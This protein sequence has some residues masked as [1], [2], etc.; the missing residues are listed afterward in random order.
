MTVEQVQAYELVEKREIQELD[1]TGYLFRHKKT[2]AR[3]CV[4]ENQ[5]PNKVFYIGFR[6]PAP[7]DTGVPHI[8]EH[9]VLCGSRLFPAK[10][11][12]VELAKGSLNTFLNAMTYPDKTVYPVA[13][14]NDQDFQNLMHVYMDAVFYP[15]IY[16]RKEI[17][18]QEGWHY[19][20][21]E[22]EGPLTLNGVVYNEMKGAFSSPEGVL[23]REIL[24]S[25]YPDTTY[26]N[27]SGGDPDFIP[28]LKYSEFLDF[29]SRY[30]HPSN[31][32]IYLYGDCDMG[33]KLAWLDEQYLSKYDHLPI[34][35]AIQLQKPF[36]R[37]VETSRSYSIS[38]EETTQ[39][40]TYLS[41]NKS[42]STTLDAKL[43]LAMQ[44]I[45]YVLLSAPG[46]PLKQALLDA[47]IG[48][49]ILSSYDNGVQQPV[50]SII[51]KNA[52]A[53]QKEAFV[54]TIEETLSRIAQEGINERALEAGINFFE[55]RYREADF[56]NYPPGL[57]YGLQALDSWLY[58]DDQV[59]LHLEA[60]DNFGFMRQQVGKGYF[61]GLIRTWLLENPHGSVVI[62][63]PEQGL[64]AKMDQQLEEKL[65][66]Y[67][68]SLSQEERKALIEATQKLHAYQEEPSTQEDLEKIPMLSRE[69]IGKEARPFVNEEHKNG[70]T[71]LVFHQV[72]TH[73]IGYVS[74]IFRADKVPERLFPYMG[75]LKGILGFVDTEHYRY[76]EFFNE[77]NRK[78][79]GITSYVSGYGDMRDPRAYTA[80]FEVRVKT[81]YENLEFAFSM[82]EEMLCRSRFTDEKRLYEIVAQGKSRLQMVMNTAGHSMASL[83]ALSYFSR[84]AYLTDLTGG[85]AFY[86]LIEGL[87][88]DFAGRKEE[89]IQNLQEL[90]NL[91]IR[92]ENLVVSYTGQEESLNRTLDY[93]EKLAGRLFTGPVKT[94]GVDFVPVEKNEGLRTS[95]KIQYV[96]MAGN[97][98]EAGLPY[99]GTLK[100][101]RT[102]MSYDYLWNHVRVKGGAYGC[103]NSYTRNG[104][105]YL[106]SYRD[107]N[108]EKT[109]QVYENSVEFVKNFQIS[110]RDM[111]RFI[112]GTISDMDVPLTPHVQG[113][114][115]MGAYL[116]HMTF[117]DVQR[118]RDEVLA[119]D[120]GAIQELAPYLQAVVEQRNLCVIGNE[121]K[122]NSQREL[123][124]E[125]RNLFH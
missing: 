53:S 33:E 38:A 64:T 48:K 27:E 121:E 51:A 14:C 13:S 25:L 106:V 86:E 102:I 97:F 87:E 118:E 123:F 68:A 37:M 78:T 20:M 79:G 58:A 93:V 65:E 99:T 96:A 30:Y 77:V 81:L 22:P 12:F 54:K 3:V 50:F 35:S 104:D 91:L 57:M 120:C 16:E 85:V 21:E 105:A 1:S 119:A 116:N 17:F 56:G 83:R 94:G 80:T 45:E 70:D 111:T 10:D 41:Y 61:E 122:L 36:T 114:R 115:S 23:D 92:R 112:I 90:V 40:N 43:Y 100:V 15:N 8:M 98:R 46:A 29:H 39:D 75:I 59:F 42:V 125:L 6:T 95:S 82:L 9:S 73:G 113:I 52:N 109:L 101:L 55:F 88:A 66:N 89:F 26:A 19:E 11:P 31:S 2:R 84:S 124:G 28:E 18:L 32:Y 7:D 107:P 49:D 24:A 60:L 5:D 34:D 71:T 72:N 47:G 110:E 117:A 44:V 67:K 69:D 103:M 108:L 74:L 76:T 62:I 63:A 4:L